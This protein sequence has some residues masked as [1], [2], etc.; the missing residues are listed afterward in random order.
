MNLH[1]VTTGAGADL[2]LL[3]G[4]G[5]NNAVWSSILPSLAERYRVTL[6]ELPGHGGS[7]Y[8]DKHAVLDN[9]VDACLEAAPRQANWIGWSLGGQI[10]QRAA[11]IAPDR[12]G[13][14]MLVCSSPR[15]IRGPDWSHAML[16]NTLH[17]FA[18]ALN[19]NP[20]QTLARFLS[21]QVQG[22]ELAREAL[23]MLRHEVAERP[24]PDTRAL[25]HG[26]ALLLTVD[27]RA[28]LNRLQ[29]PTLWL[30]G[31]KDAL[32]PGAVAQDILELGIPRAEIE[33][34]KG[35]AH[36]PLI[37]HPAQS[38]KSAKQFFGMKNE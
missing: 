38:L 15:F 25:E 29:C 35:C 27:L 23:R 9:W 2:V 19:R 30:L 16:E 33:V 1:T 31:D 3:H 11:L 4:W 18:D 21:L 13:K 14:M 10:A 6:I 36:A 12:I 17:Q 37:S 24:A 34:L 7:S 32:V 5:M 28:Q 26:L 22:D 20:R 8:C